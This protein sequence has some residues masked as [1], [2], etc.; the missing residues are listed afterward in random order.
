MPHLAYDVT[1]KVDNGAT[2]SPWDPAFLSMAPGPQSTSGAGISLTVPWEQFVYDGS[3]YYAL[4]LVTAG[5]PATSSMLLNTYV[6][7]PNSGLDAQ[8]IMTYPVPVVLVH[9][10]WGNQQSLES[11][12]NYLQTTSLGSA[13]SYFVTPICYSQYLAYYAT[14]DSLPGSNCEQTSTQALAS[15]FSGLYSDLDSDGIVGSRADF[16][17]HSMG[18]LVA[19]NFSSSSATG[20][21]YRNYR[22]RL[23]GAFRDVITLDT[24]ENGSMIAWYLDNVFA[25]EHMDLDSNEISQDLYELAC[26]TSGPTVRDCLNKMFLGWVHLPLAYPGH[27]LSEGAVA[28]LIPGEP[29]LLSLPNP[30][31]TNATW[32]AISANFHTG[33]TMPISPLELFLD[34]FLAATYPA[35]AQPITVNSML[36]ET[37]NDIIVTVPSQT[38]YAVPGQNRQ[39]SRM[40]HAP[41][42]PIGLL[43]RVISVGGVFTDANVT[44]SPEVNQQIASW[45]GY[46]SGSP[47]ANLSTRLSQNVSEAVA[48]NVGS[49]SLV[50]R[51]GQKA[52]VANERVTLSKRVEDN[53]QL[54]QPLDLQITLT[55]SDVSSITVVEHDEDIPIANEQGGTSVGSGD[56]KIVQDDG[57]VKTIEIIP[58]QLGTIS[59]E[60]L[61][62]FA[63][64]GLSKQGIQLNVHPSSKG[65][66]HFYLN[67]GFR[68]V[69]IVLEGQD[70][71][72]KLRLSPE[73]IYS[74]LDHPIYVSD[75]KEISFSVVQPESDP[76]VKLDSDGTV[77]GLRP[78]RVRVTADFD[79][80]R[81]SVT[82]NV[83]EKG[84]A[85]AG[86]SRMARP[87]KATDK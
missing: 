66:K 86:Y 78:G 72:R 37:D 59:V 54:A 82:V 35:N 69:P 25:D 55:R 1:F 39:F 45:L 68:T 14:V 53:V 83:Y 67:R 47:T 48:D 80:V 17:A 41:L 3:D 42:I 33:G 79:G 16:V 84:S 15:Y 36:G 28:S 12:Q 77:H 51:E 49:E 2:L 4:A 34:V 22:N 62:T 57:L 29:H 85:P 87:K 71:D 81:D 70:E 21:S 32:F 40:E 58:L 65:L 30:N 11:T 31:I 24:P 56:A 20:Y 38:A 60:V 50:F 26:I 46:G 7:V 10:L 63:D 8:P 64:G 43:R 76:I 74:Q 18:G 27:A 52:F 44:N 73:A 6:S 23:Q 75:S 13:P 19:R 9:G 61:V 5:T